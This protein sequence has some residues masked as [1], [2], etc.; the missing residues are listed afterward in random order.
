MS[1][2][3]RVGSMLKRNHNVDFGDVMSGN[4]LGIRSRRFSAI[5][6]LSDK[7]VYELLNILYEGI[8]L[9]S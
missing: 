1:N 5:N 9:T 2:R 7:Q 4:T 3:H 6:N 8:F